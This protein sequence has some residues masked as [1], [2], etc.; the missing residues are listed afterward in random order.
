MSRQ[1][2]RAVGAVV[3]TAPVVA[4]A[5]SLVTLMLPPV[6]L[7][8]VMVSGPAVLTSVTSPLLLLVAVNV[9]TALVPVSV[10]PAPSWCSRC[11]WC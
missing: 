5:P 8:L 11:P 10:A 1:V 2:D 6:A 9:L 4:S 3:A 7:M